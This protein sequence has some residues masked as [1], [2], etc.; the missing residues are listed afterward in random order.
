MATTN[1]PRCYSTS[2]ELSDNATINNCQRIVH[3]VQ[4]SSCGAV[5]GIICENNNSIKVSDSLDAGSL[6]QL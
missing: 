1:C 6:L 5:L 4:C 2:F 3:F